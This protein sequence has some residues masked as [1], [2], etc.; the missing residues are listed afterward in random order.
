[1]T[2][3]QPQLGLLFL[4]V[5][6]TGAGK[7]TL[8]KHVL[9]RL[10]NLQQ[11]PT[12]TTRPIRPTEQEGREHHF[13]DVP[14]FE[15]MIADG[16]L[17]EWEKVHGKNYYG[18]PRRTVA[19]SIQTAQDRIADVDVLGALR[20]RDAFPDNTLMIFVQP[21]ASTALNDVLALIRERLQERGEPEA[22][23]E[24]RL[25]RVAMEMDYAPLSDYLVV[26]DEVD[27]AGEMLYG[28]ILAER[29]KRTLRNLRVNRDQVR[30]PLIQSVM[31]VVYHQSQ[32]L[33]HEQR[34]P[35][36][37]LLNGELPQ[38]AALRK[39][40]SLDVPVGALVGFHAPQALTLDESA[41][42]TTLCHWQ[43]LP[44]EGE[45]TSTHTA[46]TWQSAESVAVLPSAVREHILQ[47]AHIKQS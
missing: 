2:V 19:D 43:C 23:I 12:A 31:S 26:N 17:L 27:Q 14:T 29:S 3:S 47:S 40:K 28:I 44:F 13:I 6:P 38:D 33:L 20:V 35:Q 16:E 10:P 9:E 46:Y 45:P 11:L 15:Q 25:R 4:L 24:N 37:T 22:E 41:Y 5:G 39:L 32:V 18:V 7:N 30:R 42:Y 8:M 21:G 36:A 34:I 1:M